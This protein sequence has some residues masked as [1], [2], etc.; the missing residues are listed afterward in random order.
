MIRAKVLNLVKYSCSGIILSGGLNTRMGGKNKAFMSVGGQ[1]I[2]DRLSKT[3]HGLF[4][5]VLL[6][7]KDPLQYLSWDLTIVKDLF[8]MRSSLT[9]IHAGLFHTTAPHAFITACDTPFLRLELI[10]ALLDALEP[11]WDVIMPVTEQGN[12]PLCAIYS[13]RCIKPIERQLK[14]GDP[15]IVNFFPKVKVKEIPEMQLRSADPHLI[16][17][18]NI[19]TPEDL[20]ASEKK[21][22]DAFL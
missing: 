13:R 9:G 3:F 1:R 6:V 20:V 21:L 2:L 14:D 18:F 7:T 11:R 4:D 17:F 5:E 12:Q 15:K 10:K 22:I 8:S 16:S 19:N